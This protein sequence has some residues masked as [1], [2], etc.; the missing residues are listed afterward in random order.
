MSSYRTS[1]RSGSSIA[2]QSARPDSN[3]GQTLTTLTED[4]RIFLNP[5]IQ[6]PGENLK[7]SHTDFFFTL[8]TQCI[9]FHITVY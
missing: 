6:T 9:M 7:L 1:Q 5:S 2:S 4:F 3:L 8:Y